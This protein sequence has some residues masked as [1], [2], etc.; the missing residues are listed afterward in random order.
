M[1]KARPKPPSSVSKN[2]ERVA[3]GI[4]EEQGEQEA[5]CVSLLRGDAT[6]SAIA[7]LTERP[8]N[9]NVS[10]VAEQ[11][12]E[13]L[14]PWIDLASPNT[15]PGKSEEHD[16][17]MIYC[18]DLSSAFALTPIV[19]LNDL[20][21]VLLDM[22]AS[23]GGKGIVSWRS[24]RPDFV[25]ANEV[26]GKRT[27]ALISN[28][29]RCNITP[30]VVTSCDSGLL[31]SLIPAVADVVIVD[32]PCSG[33]SLIVKGMSAP[34]AF[35]RAT[36]AMNERRQRRILANSATLVHPGGYL[37]YSTCTF[38]VEENE[39][40]VEWFCKT[41]PEFSSV[42]VSAMDTF[43]SKLTAEYSYR[44]FP[45]DGF[46]AGAFCCLLRRHGE[47]GVSTVERIQ[48]F[49]SRVHSVWSSFGLSASV[50]IDSPRAN[51]T[52]NPPVKKTRQRKYSG[53]ASRR[54][55]I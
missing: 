40:N 34:G 17:G 29:E 55:R 48:E 47:R 43:R 16:S 28:Y 44:L 14:A 20:K 19:M 23:P 15:N 21:G 35:H 42:S 30:A 7:W 51:E 52:A 32:A 25:I 13:W 54:G 41:F 10:V 33:Q 3:R 4:F 31:A 37:L 6:R 36:I 39:K 5:F 18:L 22:C 24:L 2:M 50:A 53:K 1:S 27:A 9:L 26:I 12:P 49:T 8:A 38:S 45:N 11:R 46:G